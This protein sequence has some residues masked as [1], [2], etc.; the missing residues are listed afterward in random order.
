M[1]AMVATGAAADIAQCTR[2]WIAPRLGAPQT[3]DPALAEKL[4]TET[5]AALAIAR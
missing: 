4:L 5:A 1:L 3:P 2:H